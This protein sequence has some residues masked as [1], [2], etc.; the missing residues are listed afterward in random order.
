MQTLRLCV[1]EYP[2]RIHK[3]TTL[4]ISQTFV[5]G[6]TSLADRIYAVCY[7]SD[8]IAVFTL[9]QPFTRL[10]GIVVKGLLCPLDIAA[11]VNIGCLYVSDAGSHTVWRIS[12]DDGAVVRWMTGLCAVSASVTFEDKVVLL[13][14]VDAQGSWDNRNSTWLGEV[15]V[16]STD[17]VVETV[18]KL[19]PDI[20][21]PLSVVMTTRKTLIV[22]YGVDWHE[23]NGV[24]EVDMTGRV[25]KAF[26]SSPGHDVSQLNFPRQV[27]LDDTDR[28]IVAD[29][30]NSRVLMLNEQLSSPRVLLTWHP[31]ST[32]N[33][34][35]FPG[36][37]HYDRHTGSLL[38]G[39][40]SSHVV[41]Y[42]W[43]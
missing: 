32:G 35:N 1:D 21:T 31:Q 13:V 25:L 40:T 17:A 24:C 23:V 30:N 41:V 11:S 16:C 42:K 37:V 5:M 27:S 29:N 2:R 22:S 8:V 43:K 34:A 36:T 39:L 15:R 38:V 26:G 6:V 10:Q 14:M 33:K 9:E 4:R 18:I 12:V 7:D 19:S 3:V 28:V 20:T